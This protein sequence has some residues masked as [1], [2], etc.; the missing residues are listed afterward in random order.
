MVYFTPWDSTN[1]GIFNPNN[2]SFTTRSEIG[3]VD[4]Y[5]QGCLH[6]NGNIYLPPANATNIGIFNPVSNSFTTFSGIAGG[7]GSACVIPDGRVILCPENIRTNI[8]IFNPATNSFTLFTGVYGYNGSCVLPDGR[9]V[10]VGPYQTNIGIFNPATNSFTTISGVANAFWGCN[11]LL[12]GRVILS[13][14]VSAQIGFVSGLNLRV[15]PEFCLHPFFN[16]Q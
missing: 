3:A 10:M 15:P 12:D 5:T 8:G 13:P 16:T 11:L 2:N 14:D 6:P 4:A 1:I 9:V 7:Y